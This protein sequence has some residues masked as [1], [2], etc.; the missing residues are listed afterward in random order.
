MIVHKLFRHQKVELLQ[1]NKLLRITWL[2][3]STY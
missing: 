2:T 3:V 1:V